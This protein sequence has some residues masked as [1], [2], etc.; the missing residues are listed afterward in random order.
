VLFDGQGLVRTR[1]IGALA[2]D[3]SLDRSALR[4]VSI[5]KLSVEEAEALA[6]DP[7]ELGVPE[8]LVTR[9]VEGATVYA[10]DGAHEIP[11]R[12][13]AADPTG[14]GDAFAAGYLAARAH[15]H[16]PAS[17]ARRATA[18]VAALLGGGAR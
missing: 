15:G 17:A 7:R 2:L 3:G 13:V 11:A 14:A 16:V 8:V 6:D 12:R 5:L 4:H 1:K 10:P 18:L 9:G